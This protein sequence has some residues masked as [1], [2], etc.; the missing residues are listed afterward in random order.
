MIMIFKNLLL[1]L[2]DTRNHLILKQLVE[3]NEDLSYLFLTKCSSEYQIVDK[4]KFIELFQ[5]IHEKRNSNIIILHFL[6]NL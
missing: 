3:K 2:A 5:L 6:K 1:L 4:R